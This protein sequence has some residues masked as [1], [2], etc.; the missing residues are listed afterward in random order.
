MSVEKV[1]LEPNRRHEFILLFD[2]KSGNPNGDPDAGNLPRIDPE[3]M[4][5]LITDVALKRKVRDY[6]ALVLKKDIF[7][8]SEVALNTLIFEA[9][10]EAGVEPLQVPLNETEQEDEELL[11][12]LQRKAEAGFLLD[13]GQLIYS[14]EA[15]KQREIARLLAEGLEEERKDLARKLQQ[16]AQRLAEATKGYKGKAITRETREEARKRL[17]AKYFD[18]RMFGAVLATGLNAGQVRGPVQLTFARSVDPIFPLD[19]S[20]TRQART[21]QE[22]LATGNTEMGRKPIVPYGLYRTHGFYNPFLAQQ[23][24]V[25]QEDLEALWEALGNLFE[26]D[27]SAS[28]GEMHVRGLWVFTHD[29]AKGN[30]PAHKLFELVRVSRK[31]GVSVPRSFNDYEVMVEEGNV[32]PGVTLTRLV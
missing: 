27:R 30:A 3:T 26:Y 15:L 4:H 9:F 8:K 28:R 21:T 23:T 22:R 1:H 24:E 17:C 11:A 25:S 2:V 20:I 12:W 18:I 19:I 31:E 7:I 14:A 16:L 32:P 29:N 10:K 13:G 5:G 6:V